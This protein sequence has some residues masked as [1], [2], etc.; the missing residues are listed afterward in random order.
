MSINLNRLSPL[1]LIVIIL[2][3]CEKPAVVNPAD[4]N[5]VLKAP[6]LISLV[7]QADTAIILTWQNTEEYTRE[8]MVNRKSDS[9][10]YSSIATVSKDVFSYVDTSFSVDVSYSYS[11]LSK[12]SEN[13]SDNS[14]SMSKEVKFSASNLIVEI[15]SDSKLRTTWID[16]CSFEEGFLVERD[17]GSGYVNIAKTLQ[18]VTQYTDSSLVYGTNYTYRV[19]SYTTNDT[20]G[21]ITSIPMRT[22][23]PMAS[24]I[25]VSA[26][27]DTEIELN[28]VDNC[29]FENGYQIERNS[30]SGFEEL[31]MVNQNVTTFL[32]NNLDY[33][34]N[35]L[36]RVAGFTDFNVSDWATSPSINIGFPAPTGFEA[37][38]VNDSQIELVWVDNSENETGF[39]IERDSGS[40]FELIAEVNANI[41]NYLDNSVGYLTD[42]S[43]RVAAF[44]NGNLSSWVISEIKNI[45]FPSPSNL[46][47]LSINDSQIQLNWSD[48]SGNESGFRIERDSGF[49]FEEIV[50]VGADSITY[51][52]DNL[53]YGTDYSYRVAAFKNSSTSGWV[54]SETLSTNFP[55]PTNLYGNATSDSRYGIHWTDN[56]SFEEGFKVERDSGS[57]FVEIAE[58][59]ANTRTFYDSELNYGTDY[60]YRVAA[61]TAS[62]TSN[63]LTSNSVGT[64]FPM[65]SYLTAQA[66][67]DSEIDLTWSDRC[68]FEEG[69]Y[70]ERDSGSGFE[71]I[72]EVPEHI[73]DYGSIYYSDTELEYGIDYTYRVA[74]FTALN[75]SDWTESVSTRTLFPEPSNMA[76]FAIGDSEIELTWKD[77]CS[78]E[79]GFK[80]ERDS[81]FGFEQITQLNADIIN[82]IDSGLSTGIIYTYRVRAF[83]TLNNSDFTTPLTVTVTPYV[84]SE[85]QIGNQ[86]WM[87]ENLRERYYRNGE[88]IQNI[89]DYETWSN[90]SDGA[91]CYYDNDASNAQTFGL[92]YNS[93]TVGDSRNIAPVGWHVPTDEEW[94]ELEMFL[95]MT[96][97]DANAIGNSRGTNEASKLAGDAIL[98]GNAIFVQNPEFGV[99]GFDALPAG[100]RSTSSDVNIGDVTDYWCLAPDSIDGQYVRSLWGSPQISRWVTSINYLGYS[101]R[102]IKD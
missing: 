82:Y 71:R 7:T 89:T 79:E 3:S 52:D 81:G 34:T 73:N 65:S 84:Y 1:I 88:L 63:W 29:S 28:W 94:Q 32:D 53:K 76:G 62:N 49:G 77:N 27:S 78:F 64:I 36:Y 24:D 33:S 72:A 37:I 97:G 66:V 18:N 6:I 55:A 8:F 25:T 5:Y 99:S 44:S 80:I 57:G 70:I 20:S 13:L 92:L 17:F 87:G 45:D 47:T 75:I 90:L 95:G 54:T 35:Y 21:W 86:I 93:Y 56:C 10:S 68:G 22:T 43:Y 48:N 46:N 74:G 69:F 41:T 100:N 85:I 9:S 31:A 14:N 42:Y 26:I 12:V 16:S 101:I 60:M 15:I 39:R 59:D 30:G 19:A 102:C 51:M 40:G 67:S 61:Y 38:V 91:C 98:W 4:P 58:L 11:V 50:D 2:L 96:Q 23:F 83:T